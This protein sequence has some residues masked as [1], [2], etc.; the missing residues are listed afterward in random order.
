[1]VLVTHD[2]ARAAELADE[3]LL[4]V[5]GESVALPPRAGRDAASLERHYREAVE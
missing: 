4:L 5:R 3:I 1:V 2:L